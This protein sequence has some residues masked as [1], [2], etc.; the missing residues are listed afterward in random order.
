ML[1]YFTP[2]LNTGDK[3]ILPTTDFDEIIFTQRLNYYKAVIS[4]TTYY[5]IIARY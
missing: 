5:R 2:T 3:F 1:H 4:F